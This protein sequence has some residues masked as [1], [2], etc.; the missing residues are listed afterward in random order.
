MSRP[1]NPANTDRVKVTLMLPPEI[2]AALHE[3]R[4]R[5]GV[6]MQHVIAHA[7]ADAVATLTAK[8]KKK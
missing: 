3:H 8:G 7:V 1:A 4:A 2:V 6:P 5:T